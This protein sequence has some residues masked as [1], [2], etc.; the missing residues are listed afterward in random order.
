MERICLQAAIIFCALVL[1]AVGLSG[2]LLGSKFLHGGESLSVDNLFRFLSAIAAGMG[3]MFITTVP[4]IEIHGERMTTLSF[5][6][7]VGGLAHL[8]GFILRPTPSFGTLIALV[9]ELIVVPLLWLGQRHVAHKAARS[10][11]LAPA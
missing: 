7:V 5:L 11:Q 1:L 2:V 3:V 6:I 10:A 8:Y 4:R 9:M